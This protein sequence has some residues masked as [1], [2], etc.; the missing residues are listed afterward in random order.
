MSRGTRIL[1]R[2][3]DLPD[4]ASSA[5]PSGVQLQGLEAQ[6]ISQTDQEGKERLHGRFIL[7]FW[8]LIKTPPH[9]GL[10]SSGG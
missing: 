6:V 3:L 9:F 5:F 2:C 1:G 4:W 7:C 10:S 8:G